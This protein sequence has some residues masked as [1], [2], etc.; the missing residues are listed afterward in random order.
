M[1]PNHSGG[2]VMLCE[3]DIISRVETYIRHPVFAG[4]DAVLRDVLDDLEDKAQAD[5]IGRE[6]YRRLRDRILGSKHF[7]ET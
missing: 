5:Q 6:T 2:T 3:A 7:R 1:R 4:S